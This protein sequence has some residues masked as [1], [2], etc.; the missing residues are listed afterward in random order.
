ML[1]LLFQWSGKHLPDVQGLI[2]SI[3]LPFHNPGETFFFRC[4]THRFHSSA[5]HYFFLATALTKDF[6][7][8][9]MQDL[10]I[11]FLRKY[12]PG[13]KHKNLSVIW[14]VANLQKYQ[15][16]CLTIYCLYNL[17]NDKLTELAKIFKLAICEYLSNLTFL[18]AFCKWEENQEMEE[19]REDKRINMCRNM[20]QLSRW[21]RSL[22]TANI[23]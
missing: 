11:L 16:S 14:H 9:K 12:Y 22:G 7:T 6:T 15:L 5:S 3:R 19:G 23:C 10:C 18:K 13:L 21:R 8:A 17:W 2:Q 20:Y 4:H 1:F